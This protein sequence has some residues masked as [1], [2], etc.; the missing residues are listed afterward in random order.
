M[1][2]TVPDK[3]DENKGFK[4][5]KTCRLY[6]ERVEEAIDEIS[7]LVF[8]SSELPAAA[9]QGEGAHPQ[10]KDQKTKRPETQKTTPSFLFTVHYS[11]SLFIPNHIVLSA[12]S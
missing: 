3:T 11:P 5:D 9:F 8:P 12:N 7:R 6:G 10:L 2:H 1:I 4:G